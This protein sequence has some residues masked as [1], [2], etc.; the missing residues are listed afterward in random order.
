MI[1]A[2]K[3][4]VCLNRNGYEDKEGRR[5][6]VVEL[7][8][9]GTRRVLNTFIHVRAADFACG[10]VQPS[11]PDHDL[12]NRRVR[13]IVRS[14]MELEDEM[15]E[16]A[17]EPT[18]P[19]VIDAFLHHQTPSATITEWVDAVVEPSQRSKSTK[20]VYRTLCT[21]LNAFHPGIRLGDLN[22]D[23]IERWQNWMRNEHNLCQNTVS[24]RLKVLRC[25]VN[26]AIKRDVLRIDQDPFR[27]IT[28]PEITPRQEHLTQDELK[29]LEALSLA[30]P[31]MMMVRDAFLF[32][33]YTGLRWCDFHSLTTAN[34][35]SAP[36][37]T[38]L[39]NLRQQK[40]RKALCLPLSALFGGK[41][42]LLIRTYGTIER[43]ADIGD[44]KTA[45]ATLRDVGRLAG[46][47][48]RLHWHL[49]RHTCATILNQYGLTTQ[50]ISYI[51]GHK[52]QQTTERHYVVTTYQQVCQ[53]LIRTL[54]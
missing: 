50:E 43:L 32:C 46:I 21:S 15:I 35:Q 53:S 36:D 1:A 20:A 7:Y 22:H 24:C 8:Q 23:V 26:E 40:T 31:R 41:P 19:R 10:R 27:H 6:V 37:G 28:I 9:R 44:N 38:T 51:L 54:K 39:L 42:L 48:M 25:L 30:S 4:N 49:A 11:H 14:L 52:K 29:T 34:L 2:I 18:P 17:M 13:R 33:C 45:N 5:Q 16:R 3:Y 47:T 12:M